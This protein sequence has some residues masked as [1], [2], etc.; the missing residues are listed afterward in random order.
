MEKFFRTDVACEL[1]DRLGGS[2]PGIEAEREKLHGLAVRRV[3]VLT[4]EAAEKL[5]RAR[6]S[7]FVLE[8]PRLIGKGGAL[9]SAAAAV[10]ELIT[11]CC[12]LSPEGTVLVAAL[13]NPDITPDAVGPL[14]AQW[15]PVTRH[16]KKLPEFS[17]LRS[18]CL[19]RTGVLGTTGI[20]SAA[21]LCALCRAVSPELVIAV[22]ALAGSDVSSLCRSIQIC[23]TGIAPGSGV[24]NDRAPLDEAHLG[25]PVVAVGV[26]T[27]VDASALCRRED[28]ADLFVTPR[29]IDALVRDVSRVVG[30]GIDM[31]LHPGIT[32]EDIEALTG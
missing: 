9:A 22:D 15:I 27:V 5:G 25:V 17:S 23:D 4:E 2:L 18:V 3:S 31:A 8:L 29:S 7:Y 24:G 20:E 28:C 19:V 12:H 21:Q 11:R 26:P 13:G 10:G 6:G 1:F 32:A 30:W 16:L 14:A